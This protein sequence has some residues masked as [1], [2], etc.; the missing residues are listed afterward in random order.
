MGEPVCMIVPQRKG[1][2][3]R[4]VPRMLSIESDAELACAYEDWRNARSEFLVTRRSGEWQKTYFQGRIG[5]SRVDGHV[6]KLDVKPFT[7][8]A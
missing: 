6:T 7:M 1:D 2:L 3:A 8:A 4:F 5:S